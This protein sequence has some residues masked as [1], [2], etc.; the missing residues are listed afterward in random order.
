MREREGEREGGREGAREGTRGDGEQREI[1]EIV[2]IKVELGFSAQCK[3]MY[4]G[5]PYTLST[6]TCTTVI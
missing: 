3:Y 1:G 4:H 6:C 5:H 2:C